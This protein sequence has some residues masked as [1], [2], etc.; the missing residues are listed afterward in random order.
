MGAQVIHVEV[1]GKDG[2][3]LQSFYKDVFGWS[4]DTNNPGGY[5]MFRQETASPAA[6]ARRRTAA[7][8]RHVLRPLGRPAGRARQGR[9]HGRSGAHAAD[10]GRARDD[11]RPVRRSRGPRRRDHVGPTHV[12]A[13]LGARSSR[14]RRTSLRAALRRRA[15]RP[16]PLG[17]H[18]RVDR[19]VRRTLSPVRGD[20]RVALEP[21]SIRHGLPVIEAQR[22]PPGSADAR[23][24]PAS[25]RP[26][27]ANVFRP[28]TM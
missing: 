18:R 10:R 11:D 12:E 28:E 24:A 2:A 21:G 19:R 4:L 5:G 8:A 14:A 25:A 6:S 15:G 13:G 22:R 23:P 16:G 7:R 20:P 26:S 9:G 27:R 3:K 1:T 17:P